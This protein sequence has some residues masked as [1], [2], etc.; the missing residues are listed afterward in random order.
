MYDYPNTYFS[1]ERDERTMIPN[2]R[3][4]VHIPASNF[5]LAHQKFRKFRHWN[6]R[7]AI[8]IGPWYVILCVS[9]RSSKRDVFWVGWWGGGWGHDGKWILWLLWANNV[10]CCIYWLW[11]NKE[12]ISFPEHPFV[13]SRTD[14]IGDFMF[15]APFRGWYSSTRTC[16]NSGTRIKG[17]SFGIEPWHLQLLVAMSSFKTTYYKEIIYMGS[18]DQIIF[19]EYSKNYDTM[20]GS[21]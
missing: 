18:V 16:R 3:L 1:N 21:F 2:Y 9:K 14:R 13:W 20:Q 7:R 15:S 10:L 5:L 4:S 11:Y 17:L 12:M 19:A 6:V 8:W